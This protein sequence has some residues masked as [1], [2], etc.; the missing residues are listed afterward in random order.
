MKRKKRKKCKNCFNPTRVGGPT[1][2][3]AT[4]SVITF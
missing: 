4:K 1:D 2:P 3:P